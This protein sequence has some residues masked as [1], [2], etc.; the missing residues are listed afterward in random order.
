MRSLHGPSLGESTLTD[1]PTTLFTIHGDA[2]IGP[3][4]RPKHEFP[5]PEL[6][7]SHGP[8][9]VIA[10]VNQTGGVGK[11]T[12]SLNL[13]A[14]VQP[15]RSQATSSRPIPQIPQI[16]MSSLRVICAC[17]PPESCFS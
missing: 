12:S 5:E 4:G 1:E 15:P 10:M 13:A 16:P 9:R 7:D 17:A 6:L 8:A 3:T 2:I 14:A 11:T